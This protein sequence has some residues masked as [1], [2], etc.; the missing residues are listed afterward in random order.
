MALFIV[1]CSSLEQDID[2]R[3][4]EMK[5]INQ[6]NQTNETNENTV[7]NFRTITKIGSFYIDEFTRTK[8]RNERFVNDYKRIFNQ[9]DILFIYGIDRLL[10]TEF[11]DI[12]LEM[13][14]FDYVIR[15][16]DTMSLFLYDKDSVSFNKVIEHDKYFI[17]E[18]STNRDYNIVLFGVHIDKYD[19]TIEIRDLNNIVKNFDKFFILGTLWADCLYY[20]TNELPDLYWIID[21]SFD[22]TTHRTSCAYDRI[23][24]P[25]NMKY[26]IQDFGVKDIEIISNHKPIY[27]ILRS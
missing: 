5:G 24:V 14:R 17:T 16:D 2:S 23:I 1:G 26:D 12:L 27:A 10:V 18:F 8:S 11:T 21:D 4:D 25:K 3:I 15:A 20:N 7:G 9:Y 6:T 19:A 13:P 22:T